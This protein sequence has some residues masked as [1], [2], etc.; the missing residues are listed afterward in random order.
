MNDLQIRTAL[1]QELF[2]QF[3]VGSEAFILDEV[4][5]RHGAARRVLCAAR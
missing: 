2:I 3:S 4:G 5:L 1:K